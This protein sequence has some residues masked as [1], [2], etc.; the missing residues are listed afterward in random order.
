VICDPPP[1][2]TSEDIQGK[3]SPRLHN[4]QT[5]LTRSSP[6]RRV[7]GKSVS[8]RLRSS[9]APQ[10]GRQLPQS[11]HAAEA[12][13]QA[14]QLG[15]SNWQ[16]GP[17]ILEP[18]HGRSRDVSCRHYSSVVTSPPSLMNRHGGGARTSRGDGC[19]RIIDPSAQRLADGVAWMSEGALHVLSRSCCAT[20]R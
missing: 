11:S 2:P 3:R 7:V 1:F 20:P 15:I 18:C 16:D 13:S 10:G 19:R 14:G 17:V 6:R 5:G 4:R 8:M 12:S 9:T